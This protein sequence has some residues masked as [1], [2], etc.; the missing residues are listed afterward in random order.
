[1]SER[2]PAL[3]IAGDW[4]QRLADDLSRVELY[5]RSIDTS[6]TWPGELVRPRRLERISQTRTEDRGARRG[7]MQG[8]A[9]KESQGYFEEPQR[10]RRLRP[11]RE[12]MGGF[13]RC[14]LEA[15]VKVVPAGPCQGFQ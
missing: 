4:D 11:A 15:I 13:M 6:A 2:A 12:P 8:A 14:A 1:M 10:S 9:T 7:W 5:R 3:F